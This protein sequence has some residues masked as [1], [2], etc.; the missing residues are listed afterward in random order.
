MRDGDGENE[1]SEGPRKK[2]ARTKDGSK[3]IRNSS[4]KCKCGGKD[5]KRT[6]WS[7]C[8]WKGLSRIQVAKNYVKR[9]EEKS[10]NGTIIEPTGIP[11]EGEINFSIVH[12]T[13]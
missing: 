10:T 7:K 8:P 5:H 13:S 1:E 4:D 11:V 3:L 6:L 2:R 9:I 12:F